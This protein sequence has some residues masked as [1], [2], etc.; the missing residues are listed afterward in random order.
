MS[1]FGGALGGLGLGALLG[2]GFS[3]PQ[4]Q[5]TPFDRA[6]LSQAA[7]FGPQHLGALQHLA[8]GAVGCRPITET[9]SEPEPERPVARKRAWGLFFIAT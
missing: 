8:G 9:V 5:P 3:P 6:L 1:A 7:Q 4:R 2:G